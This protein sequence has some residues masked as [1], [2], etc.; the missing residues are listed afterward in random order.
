MATRTAFR[1]TGA[2]F[3]VGAA[4]LGYASLIERNLFISY[5]RYEFSFLLR[6]IL[7]ATILI[8]IGLVVTPIIQKRLARRF[9]VREELI[10][11]GKG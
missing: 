8:G 7:I 10:A 6:P 5:S 1:L 2:T 4:T 11:A 3:L 9:A